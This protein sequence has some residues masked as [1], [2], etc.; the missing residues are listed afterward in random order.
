M[1]KENAVA[2]RRTLGYRSMIST[3]LLAPEGRSFAWA[4]LKTQLKID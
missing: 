2:I 4:R 1:P 3:I